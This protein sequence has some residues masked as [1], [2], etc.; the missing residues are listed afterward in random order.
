MTKRLLAG[1]GRQIRRAITPF[2]A[3]RGAQAT[4]RKAATVLSDNK[5]ARGPGLWLARRLSR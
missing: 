4:P 5:P 3:K 1:L 2:I